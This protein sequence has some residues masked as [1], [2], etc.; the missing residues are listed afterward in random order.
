MGK[1]YVSLWFRHLL[2]DW[3]A[4]RQQELLQLPF[5]I[6]APDHG[7]LV[8]TA[9]NVLA[10]NQGISTGMAVAD[11]KALV[12]S[13]EVVN[14]SPG[15][16]GKLLKAIGEWCIRYT[17]IIAVHPPDGLLL[18]VSGCTHLW[19]GEKEYLREILTR[20]K[21]KGYYVRGA[22]ADTIGAAWAVAR[23][24]KV[25]PLVA[26][27]DQA[28]ALLSLPP[29]ALRLEPAIVLRL[30][31][32]GLRTIGS[33]IAMQ[34]SA[35]RR[36]FGNELLLRLDQALGHEEESIV[37]LQPIVP[38]QERLPCLEPIRTA[39]GIETAIQR[40]LEMLCKRLQEEGMGL[41]SGIL[42]CYRVDGKVIQVQIG[43]NKASHHILHLFKLFELKIASIAPALGIEL[44]ILEAPKVE[45][46]SPFQ[47]AIWSGAPGLE[48]Q[49]IAELLDK[50]A[51]KFGADKIHRYLPAAHYWPERSIQQ[52]ASIHE[53][54]AMDWPAYQ[55]RPVQLL[56]KPERIEVTAPIPDYPPMLFI[57]KGRRHMIKKADGPERIEREWWLDK[58]EHRD[59]YSVEDEEGQRYWLFRSGHYAEERSQW[60]IHGF[61]A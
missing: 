50:L 6:A 39:V 19:G 41:R 38:Y 28:N 42:R 10:E 14:D 9:L 20:L 33:F 53:K 24:G 11:A 18:D 8:I 22:I 45:E 34:R 55:L 4:L 47:E 32:L 52:A 13:L 51:G 25:T 21:S 40:L 12:P 30:Q 31:K 37:P 27:G 15:K 5:V 29:A 57:Y 26:P 60:F 44:F 16:A 54:P 23:F 48:N 49:A 58:G 3:Q 61:F 36:R 59:Y 43:T 2:T 1:R 17:P 7:R 46:A 56:A 35:L